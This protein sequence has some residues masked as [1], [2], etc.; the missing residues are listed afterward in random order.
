MARVRANPAAWKYLLTDEAG[1]GAVDFEQ[2]YPFSPAL[3][4]AMVALSSI[5]Q[6]ERTAL[7]IMSELL[8]RGRDELTVGDVIPVG[9]LFDVVVLGDAKPLTEDM[10]ASSRRR[11]VLPRQDAPLPAGEAHAQRG[12][13]AEPRR[14]HAFRREDRLAKTL[15]VAAIAPGSDVAEGPHGVQARRAE[16]RHVVSMFGGQRGRSGRDPGH[17]VASGVRRGHRRL[18][19]PTRSS[20]CS[21]PVWTTTR[22]SRTSARGHLREPA[23]ADPDALVE[24]D[25]GCHHRVV[26]SEYTL[27]H[28]WRGQ[29]RA[30]D[31]VFG[32]IR[33][34]AALPIEALTAADGRWKLVVDFPFDDRR[35][36][37]VGRRE[38]ICRAQAGRRR[39]GH[40]RL[41]AALLDRRAHGRRRQ[42]RPARSTCS[43][44]SGSTSTPPACRSNDREPAR[45]QLT[46]QRD[47]LRSQLGRDCGRPTASTPRN[48]E[49][50]G[51]FVRTVPTSSPWPMGSRRRSPPPRRLRDA[52]VGVLGSALD[53]RYPKHPEI[54]RGAEEVRR[55]ELNSVLDLARRAVDA[56][57]RLADVDRATGSRVR[58]VVTGFGVGALRE[59][60]YALDA[61]HFA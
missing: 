16:L 6:R 5:M 35:T 52:V 24:R 23:Q 34:T 3:V 58:R 31:V 28:V 13:R 57:G 49:N 25:R 15:L 40:H 26:G 53:A 21:C 55:A 37:T 43:P 51:S 60:T 39:R 32:N 9:D 17:R 61:Q 20:R 45:Q 11:G 47:S 2:V 33:D 38:R 50:L 1:S 7:K 44:V 27:D 41:G 18:R 36:R 10:E 22:S 56:G 46:N 4:D 8:C 19:P 12:R 48:E 59:T 29:K 54:E 14:S 42:A 30:V